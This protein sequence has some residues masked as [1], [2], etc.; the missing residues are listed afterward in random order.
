M[1]AANRIF[2]NMFVQDDDTVKPFGIQNSIA[3]A[4]DYDQAN[5]LYH[6]LEKQAINTSYAEERRAEASTLRSEGNYSFFTKIIA[7][8]LFLVWSSKRT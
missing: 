6:N 5:K 3:Q 2:G 4:V 1:N 7:L 8:G